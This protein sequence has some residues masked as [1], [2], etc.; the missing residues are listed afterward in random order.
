MTDAMGKI[1][2]GMQETEILR[3]PQPFPMDDGEV[4]SYF[5]VANRQILFPPYSMNRFRNKK[6]EAES[7]PT[8]GPAK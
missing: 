3:G 2:Q 4:K 1:L 6:E 5:E 7:K 8:T